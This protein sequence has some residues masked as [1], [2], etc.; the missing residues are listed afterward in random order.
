VAAGAT[1]LRGH[2]MKDGELRGI[3]LE[4]FYEL[5]NQQ[6]SMLNVLLLPDIV[7]LDP[8]PNRLLNIYDQ[9]GEHGL[10]HWKSLGSFS[11]VE[12]WARLLPEVSM[13]LRAPPRRP[14]L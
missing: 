3:V 11:A 6:P 10:I 4:K 5:R 13:S 1:L 9:L 7:S 8:N 12:A 2:S 14:S